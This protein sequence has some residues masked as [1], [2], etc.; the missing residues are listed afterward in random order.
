MTVVE[1]NSGKKEKTGS[2]MDQITDPVVR[3]RVTS[4]QTWLASEYKAKGTWARVAAEI[5][6]YDESSIGLF[7]RGRYPGNPVN[8]L[9]AIEQAREFAE[10]RQHNVFRPVFTDTSISKRLLR[11]LKQTRSRGALGVVSSESGVGK[12]TTWTEAVKT[13]H[14][15]LILRANPTLSFKP[16]PLVSTLLKVAG[17]GDGKRQSPA[18]AFEAL[19]ETFRTSRKDLIIDE[20]QFVSRDGLDILRCLSEDAG[21]SILFS[22]NEQIYERGLMLRADPAAFVQFQS[23][24]LVD[25]HL[26]T[27]HITRADVGLI[28]S[29]LLSEDVLDEE[30]SDVLLAQAQAPGGFRRLTCVLQRAFEKAR[31]RDITRA[32]VLQVVREMALRGGVS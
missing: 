32:Q 11:A 18:H 16:W 31:S 13:D 1:M 24:C 15:L 2:M 29:Q 26:K 8:M 23:R 5:G 21:I 22:G 27:A 20:A 14:R 9:T 28:A 12:S 30:I 7:A 25:E 6:G 19:R 4:T 3:E 10:D 17:Q